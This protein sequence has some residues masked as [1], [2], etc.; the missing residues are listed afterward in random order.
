MAAAGCGRIVL[1]SRSQPSPQALETIE[2]I[3]A[4]GTD[5]EVE[6]GDITE[7][8]TAARLVTVATA[9]G[10]PLRGVLHAAAVFENA[11][12]ANMTDELIDRNWAPKV[13]GAWNLHQATATAAPG[14]VLL[15]LVGSGLWA[16]QGRGVRRGQQLAGRLRALAPSPGPSRHCDR[17]GLWAEVGRAAELRAETGAAWLSGRAAKAPHRALA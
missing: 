5:I 14:L 2:L 4:M 12:L 15:V 10:L 17:V 7:V 8:G 6:C 13:Y 9:T 11:M 16:R 3:R 1:S